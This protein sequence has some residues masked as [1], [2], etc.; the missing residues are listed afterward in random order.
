MPQI[1][2]GPPP[3]QMLCWDLGGAGVTDDGDLG[4]AL[5][6]RVCWGRRE[7]KGQ[8]RCSSQNIR[9]LHVTFQ[10]RGLGISAGNSVPFLFKDFTNRPASWTEL[11]FG[12][13]EAWTHCLN[14]EKQLQMQAK[15]TGSGAVHLNLAKSHRKNK[16]AV[17]EL[18]FPLCLMLIIM[19]LLSGS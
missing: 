7:V 19:L 6:V 1:L 13:Y 9:F 14:M 12:L 4:P 3:C 16:G 2:C 11:L 15:N 18:E 17:L 5:E 8:R 10:G